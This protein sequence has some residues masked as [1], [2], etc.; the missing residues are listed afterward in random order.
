MKSKSASS[1]F[2]LVELIISI[3]IIAILSAAAVPRALQY[4]DKAKMASDSQAAS[5]YENAFE[6]LIA[7][8]DIRVVSSSAISASIYI[9]NADMADPELES[10]QDIFKQY[11]DK[12]NVSNKSGNI[13]VDIYYN[14][15]D[16]IKNK[17]GYSITPEEL[18]ELFEENIKCASLKYYHGIIIDFER[19]GI[20]GSM[21]IER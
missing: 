4:V 17:N 11:K 3:S 6:A 2:T 16:G 18:K 14:N 19:K 9:T 21:L 5:A 13:S 1:G 15:I 20:S 10:S 12:I 8:G 7:S